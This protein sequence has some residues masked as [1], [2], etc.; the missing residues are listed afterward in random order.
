MPRRER[1]LHDR[2]NECGKYMIF[3]GVGA[4]LP[5]QAFGTPRAACE[6]ALKS[7][8]HKG[9]RVLRR[10][11]WYESAPQP[12]SS[13]PSYV[14]GVVEVD[15]TLPPEALLTVLHDVEAAFGRVRGARNEARVLDLDLLAYHDV[16]RPGPVPP[17]LPHP[18]MTE[19]AFVLLPLSEI[20]PGWRH[21]RSG[22]RL[23][24][25]VAAL[26]P[27]QDCRP[28]DDAAGKS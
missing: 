27:G 8:E 7:L 25:L 21:P 15:S 26:P 22:A 11:G 24:D 20:A 2:F 14:N 19:R 18:R 4:N 9:I 10:S 3:L 1:Q 12:P 13:Q 5:S 17:I 6:A 16:V 23:E 28:L